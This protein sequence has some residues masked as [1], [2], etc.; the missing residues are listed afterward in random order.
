MLRITVTTYDSPCTIQDPRPP[1][2][3]V[4]NFEPND[5]KSFDVQWDE[6]ERLGT[7]LDALAAAGF[8]TYVPA[9]TEGQSLVEQAD[10][11]GNPVVDYAA[12]GTITAASL[13]LAITGNRLLAGQVVAEATVES[14]DTPTGSVLLE[15]VNPGAQGNR[16]DV[17]IIDSLAGGLTVAVATVDSREVITIDLGGSAAETCTTVAALINNAV[18]ATYGMVHAT[19]VGVGATGVT[20][21]QAVTA[22]TG[23]VGSGMSITLAG[24][25]CTVVSID[26]TGAPIIEITL[27][28]PSLVALGLATGD[29]LKLEVR[30]GGKLTDV[31][32]DH[33]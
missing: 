6:M 24:L 28:T 22:F 23:G 15:A 11:P 31:T 8:L 13:S 4:I 26:Q 3:R 20:A 9:G 12:P 18:S 5:V 25:P 16:Y 30:S 21:L 32:L 17:Q 7:Q 2:G 19:V 27:A 1:K 10:S 29:K 14:D 33:A